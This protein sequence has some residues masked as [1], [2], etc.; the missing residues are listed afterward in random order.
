MTYKRDQEY[1]AKTTKGSHT[2]G[3]LAEDM[4]KYLFGLEEPYVEIK[5]A[6]HDYYRVVIKQPQLDR[7]LPPN[8]VYVICVYRRHKWQKYGKKGC[9]YT[10]P[11][12]FERQLKFFFIKAQDLMT[13]I[14]EDGLKLRVV[15]G[16]RHNAPLY[17]Y[18]FV[19]WK[20]LEA[21]LGKSKAI[22]EENRELGR[23]VPH[24]AWGDIPE[25]PNYDT[26]PP[27]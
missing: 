14:K 13:V 4:V 21:H 16:G 19:R 6:C 1:Y 20:A 9:K 26:P 10:I 17:S 18:Y 22:L 23:C 24:R 11:E 8:K 5:A 2:S 27:F 7:N 3:K 12:A 25:P 15:V